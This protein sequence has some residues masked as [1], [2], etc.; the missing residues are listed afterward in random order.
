M[1]HIISIRNMCNI[2]A[3]MNLGCYC[4][5]YHSTFMLSCI[6]ICVG[7]IKRCWDYKVGKGVQCVSYLI[8]YSQL[9]GLGTEQYEAVGD[10]NEAC[11]HVPSCKVARIDCAAEANTSPLPG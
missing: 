3:C 8:K 2:L 6:P 9:E 1:Q 10:Q 11:L 7:G 4:Y 5:D